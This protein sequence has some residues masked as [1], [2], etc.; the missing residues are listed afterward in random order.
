MDFVFHTIR[1]YQGAGDVC[2]NLAIDT[3]CFPTYR[4]PLGGSPLLLGVSQ[5]GTRCESGAAPQR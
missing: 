3:G 5:Q 1:N 4:I 2:D